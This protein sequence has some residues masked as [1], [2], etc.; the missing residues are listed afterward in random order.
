MTEEREFYTYML[1][2]D[3]GM[4]YV[5]VT[6]DLVTRVRQHQDGT[7]S[8]Y[9]SKY[10]CHRLVYYETFEYVFDAIEREKQIK[11]YGRKKKIALITSMNPKWFD[12]SKE[13]KA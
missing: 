1:A 9:T 2:N 6:G 12:L 5:G 11:G 7:G 8:A 3:K 10:K 4:L 13:W